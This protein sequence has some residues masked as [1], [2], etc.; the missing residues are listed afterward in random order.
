M[1]GFVRSQSGP[2]AMG[3]Y[4]STLMPFI[5][6][7]ARTYPV[8]DNY[9][10]SVMAQTYPNRRFLLAGTSMGE[11]DDDA[12][13]TTRPPNGTILEMLNTY[14][15][16]WKN[17][18]TASSHTPSYLVWLY[19]LGEPAADVSSK[20]VD[21]SNF[22]SDAAAGTLPAV[23]LV[24]PNFSTQSEENPQDVQYGDQFMS[25][26]INAVTSSPQWPSTLLVW[27]YDE[28]GGYYDHVPPPVA[29]APDGIPPVV[30]PGASTYDGFSRYGFRVPAVVVSPYAVRAGL[31]HVLHDHTSVL[32]MV[33]R[34]WNLPAMTFRDANANDLTDFLDMAALRTGTP[35]F[36]QL[37]AL[38]PSGLSGATLA[39]ST[40][41]PGTIPPPGSS[42]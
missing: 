32:A 11:I 25:Q 29:L 19:L 13:S 18:Y 42:T 4:D 10:S 14:D 39:C 6:S 2:V 33:E 17:Y 41:G 38:P 22:F 36:P 3:Y 1:D 31:T 12:A 28:G 21:I 34:K 23:S 30:P 37:P 27:T 35:T 20:A 15:I 9:F 24:D 40:T 26:V 16:S 8:C 5:N 7:L